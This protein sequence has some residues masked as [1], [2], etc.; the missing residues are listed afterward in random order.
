[1]TILL[2]AVYAR[3]FILAGRAAFTVRSKRTNAHYTFRV[4]RAT[5]RWFVKLNVGKSWVY[6]GQIR[7]GQFEVTRA[8][9]GG[10]ACEAFSWLW[11]NLSRDVMPPQVEVMHIGSCGRCGKQLTNPQSI[12]RGLGPECAEIVLSRGA[13]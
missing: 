2:T 13:Q 6:L 7:E 4:D 8:S 12:D 5:D 11:G 3:E 9:R 10:K 1:M